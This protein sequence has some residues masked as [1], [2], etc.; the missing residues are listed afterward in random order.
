MEGEMTD[1]VTV[2]NDS[3][4]ASVRADMIEW[5]LRPV[6]VFLTEDDRSL[7]AHKIDTWDDLLTACKSA[8]EWLGRGRI[9]GT[10][11]RQLVD[12]LVEAINKAGGH[13]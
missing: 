6:M 11:S 7:A 3:A 1:H 2:R 8:M 4:T 9:M 12:Q 5:G 10:S 13:V